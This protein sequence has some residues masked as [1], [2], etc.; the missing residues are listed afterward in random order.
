MHS[1]H[2]APSSPRAR[3]GAALVR[4][5]ERDALHRLFPACWATDTAAVFPGRFPLLACSCTQEVQSCTWRTGGTKLRAYIQCSARRSKGRAQIRAWSAHG[6]P[7]PAHNVRQQPSSRSLERQ[8]LFDHSIIGLK[9]AMV[10]FRPKMA[11]P[12]MDRC[13]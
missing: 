13:L 7:L 5:L 10:C 8:V 4:A 12:V 9:H 2:R 3:V 11:M 6:K 1:A